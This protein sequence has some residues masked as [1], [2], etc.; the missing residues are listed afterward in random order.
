MLV[1]VIVVA[2]QPQTIK[3]RPRIRK[4]RLRPMHSPFDFAHDEKIN[5]RLTG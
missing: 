3:V 5:A 2:E 4:L 1:V